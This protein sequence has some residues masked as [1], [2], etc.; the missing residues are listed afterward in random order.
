M[1]NFTTLSSL[2]LS[3]VGAVSLALSILFWIAS[4]RVGN[5][6]LRWVS[7][8]FVVLFIKSLFIILTIHQFGIDH[9]AVQALDS[10]FDLL[11]VLLIV[12]PFLIRHKA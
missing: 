6:R 4:S 8:G 11:A 1:S 7:A 3:L 2:T 5:M 10:V 12:A 9:E